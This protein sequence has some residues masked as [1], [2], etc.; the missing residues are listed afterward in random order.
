MAEA[1]INYG[2]AMVRKDPSTY[3]ADN[4]GYYGQK[5]DLIKVNNPF[6]PQDKGIFDVSLQVYQSEKNYTFTV[7]SIGYY[8]D[9]QGVKR[10]LEE[11]Y[12]LPK[13]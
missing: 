5:K 6:G 11:Q 9:E 1:G 7:T 13:P 3:F 2:V 4:S 8:P 12:T 10:T